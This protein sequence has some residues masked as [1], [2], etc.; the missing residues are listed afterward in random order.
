MQQFP[1]AYI[2]LHSMQHF[3]ICILEI[4]PKKAKQKKTKSQLREHYFVAQR[5]L[6]VFAR[7]GFRSVHLN[8]VL[9]TQE[10]MPEEA[11]SIVFLDGDGLQGLSPYQERREL[12]TWLKAYQNLYNSSQLSVYLFSS[13]QVSLLNRSSKMSFVKCPIAIMGSLY[14]QLLHGISRGN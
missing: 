1:K 2:I 12:K 4:F 5:P 14:I 9:P 3:S 11:F 8:T 10:E 7:L 13:L 6:V